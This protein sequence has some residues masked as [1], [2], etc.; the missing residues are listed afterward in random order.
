MNLSRKTAAFRALT[1]KCPNCGQKGI[2][3]R[4]FQLPPN[5]PHC[6][7]PLNREHGFTLGT[8]SIGYVFSLIFIL[9]PCLFFVMNGFLTVRLGVILG[10][11]LSIAFPIV[12]YPFLVR[13]VVALYFYFLAH[14][15]PA[16]TGKKF[17]VGDRFD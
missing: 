17:T 2:F 3:Q 12:T 14:E 13:C 16:N 6:E 11:V 7:L 1:G 15:L 4:P 10:V 9:A 5:C 8:T